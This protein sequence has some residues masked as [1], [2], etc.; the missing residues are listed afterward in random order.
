MRVIYRSE[1][2]GLSLMKPAQSLD[3]GKAVHDQCVRFVE[4]RAL[5]KPAQSLDIG[6]TIYDQCV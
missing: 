1:S 5:T 2:P 4:V 6:K 3:V